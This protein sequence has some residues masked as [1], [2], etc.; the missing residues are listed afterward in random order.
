MNL[1]YPY[2]SKIHILH[3]RGRD[4]NSSVSGKKSIIRLYRWAYSKGTRFD[5]YDLALAL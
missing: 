2:E 4:V 3:H 1:A 5:L